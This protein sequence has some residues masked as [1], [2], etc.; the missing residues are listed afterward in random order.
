[1]GFVPTQPRA[2]TAS[3]VVE[4]ERRLQ[5]ITLSSPSRAVVLRGV[6]LPGQQEDVQPP[7]DTGQTVASPEPLASLETRLDRLSTRIA[8]LE[9]L[10]DRL[11]RLFEGTAT[12]PVATP[13]ETPSIEAVWNSRFGLLYQVTQHGTAFAWYIASTSGERGQ[14]TAPVSRSRDKAIT[15]A[16][17]TRAGSS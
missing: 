6:G 2:Y 5:G 8:A 10:V 1:M 11:C 17:P 15:G 7:L 3:L 14:S 16:A 4:I 13:S 12:A 9:A